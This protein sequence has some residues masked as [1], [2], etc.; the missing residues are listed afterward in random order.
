MIF[1]GLRSLYLSYRKALSHPLAYTAWFTGSAICD[2]SQFFA[3]ARSI[4]P[5]LPEKGPRQS[6]LISGAH[7]FLANKNLLYYGDGPFAKGH[8][9]LRGLAR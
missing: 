9:I 8:F 1:D 2:D 5:N 3:T 6:W 7:L 4:Y